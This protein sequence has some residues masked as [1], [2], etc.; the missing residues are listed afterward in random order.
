MD[1]ASIHK[2]E[3]QRN[4][5]ESNGFELKF[6]PGYSPQLNPIEEVFSKWK[7]YIAQGNPNTNEDLNLLINSSSNLISSQD[8][9]GFFRH[10][11][12]FVL[13]GIRREDF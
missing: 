4:F 2:N 10:V 11:R 7:H 5:L 8:C 13:K 6:L 1:N 9:E 12:S 3:E